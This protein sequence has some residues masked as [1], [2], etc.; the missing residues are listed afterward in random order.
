MFVQ[1]FFCTADEWRRIWI[2]GIH[3][4]IVTDIKEKLCGTLFPSHYCI[5]PQ[6]K[7]QG[8]KD[9]DDAMTFKYLSKKQKREW[10][11]Q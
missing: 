8:A 5:I 3:E 9:D 6:D 1:R 7:Q 4:T 10:E 2:K 11:S